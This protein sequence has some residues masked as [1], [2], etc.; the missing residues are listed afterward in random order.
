MDIEGRRMAT[1]DTSGVCLVSDIENDAYKFH[2]QMPLVL[3][4]RGDP[5]T[6]NSPRVINNI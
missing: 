4:Q 5:G 3:R 1:I 2:I 6:Q